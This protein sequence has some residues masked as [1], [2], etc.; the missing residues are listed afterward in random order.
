[1]ELGA[2]MDIITQLFMSYYVEGV[3]QSKAGVHWVNT[4]SSSSSKSSTLSASGIPIL[5]KEQLMKIY[6]PSFHHALVTR[7]LTSSSTLTPCSNSS[8]S[9]GNNNSGSDEAI[10]TEIVDSLLSDS[11]AMSRQLL[12]QEELSLGGLGGLGLGLGGKSLGGLVSSSSK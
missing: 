8:G 3:L 4:N 12:M 2:Y 9:G 6:D 5:F 10:R 11:L 1:M 7:I